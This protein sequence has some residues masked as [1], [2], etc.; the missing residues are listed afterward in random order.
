MY[1]YIL[2]ISFDDSTQVSSKVFHESAE[3]LQYVGYMLDLFDTIKVTIRKEVQ[4][5]K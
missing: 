1:Q 2:L 4:S 3:L 5:C